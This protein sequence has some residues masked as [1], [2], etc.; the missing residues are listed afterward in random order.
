MCSRLNVATVSST[1]LGRWSDVMHTSDCWGGH[2]AL[3]VW[4]FV[5]LTET[6]R[7]AG[8]QNIAIVNGMRGREAQS[9]IERGGN[10]LNDDVKGR[11]SIVIMFKHQTMLICVWYVSGAAITQTANDCDRASQ[12]RMSIW[13]SLLTYSVR[14]HQVQFLLSS[15]VSENGGLIISTPNGM[16][17]GVDVDV[18]EYFE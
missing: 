14:Q 16:R 17:M 8:N 5:D 3:C 15:P 4:H 2:G 7:C 1:P 12:F 11:L 18:H 9:H 6:E 10:R 13:T